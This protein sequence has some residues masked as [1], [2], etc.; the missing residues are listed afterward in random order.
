DSAFVRDEP[1]RVGRWTSAD[2]PGT[3]VRSFAGFLFHCYFQ[4]QLFFADAD[5]LEEATCVERLQR[6]KEMP[7]RPFELLLLLHYSRAGAAPTLVKCSRG[8]FVSIEVKFFAPGPF[9]R[10]NVVTTAQQQKAYK[11]LGMEGPI[12]RWY[13]RNTGRA[14]DQYQKAAQCVAAELRGGSR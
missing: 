13:A 5:P 12:A 10:V 2:R 11:G 7:R 4:Q 1:S 14:I 9:R 8:S 6:P 3:P